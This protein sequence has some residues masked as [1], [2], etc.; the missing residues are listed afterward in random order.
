MQVTGETV[1]LDGVVYSD[2]DTTRAIEKAKLRMPNVKSLLRV[3]QVDDRDGLAICGSG[4]GRR[5]LLSART[6]STTTSCSVRAFRPRTRDG[7]ALDLVATATYKINAALTAAN[8]KSIYQEH[9]SGASGQEVAFKQGRTIYAAGCP[10]VPYGVII[11]V[12]PTLQ[13]RD[14][15]L[16]DVSV[17]VST[18]H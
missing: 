18:A 14:G 6:F 17:E 2:A 11:K 4:P 16:T 12:K 13:G 8:F 1:V 9:I 3:R 7:P 10:P 15:I 5:L